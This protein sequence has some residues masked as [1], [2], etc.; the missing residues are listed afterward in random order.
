[1]ILA[2][3]KLKYFHKY[4][5]TSTVG[6]SF[7]SEFDNSSSVHFVDFKTAGDTLSSSACN[8]D[9]P[10][11]TVYLDFLN[12]FVTFLLDLPTITSASSQPLA[13]LCIRLRAID[14]S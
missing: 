12:Q 7:K 4:E 10:T 9:A 11:W 8:A 13:I 3:S 2:L 14:D 5:E 6:L 1:M